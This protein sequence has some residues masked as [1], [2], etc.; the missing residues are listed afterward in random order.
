[1][2]NSKR[3]SL[4]AAGV[5]GALALGA[6]GAA[7]AQD[8]GAPAPGTPPPWDTLVRC[9][10]MASED[11]RLSCYDAA[12]RAA[13]YAPKPAEV[14]A[15]HRRRFGL[16]IPQV[17]II[18]HK[19]KEQGREAVAPSAPPGAS[20]AE[21]APAEENPDR[22]TLQIQQVAVVQPGGR[23]LIFT[24]DGQIWEQTDSDQLIELPRAGQEM[25]VRRNLLG[26]Y[27]CD[28]TK[29]KAVRCKRDK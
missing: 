11:A 28:V 16:S 19:G 22:I 9:A 4:W 5:A 29:Y 1:M 15:E 3:S 2:S 6:A 10:G 13:G 26:G 14:A 20:P 12:M 25:R 7:S 21:P 8:A 24:A 27:F 17:N 18:K 23:L